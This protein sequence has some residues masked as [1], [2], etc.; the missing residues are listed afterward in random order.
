MLLLSVD[1][2]TA[3]SKLFF[4][5]C[6][7]KNENAWK[8]IPTETTKAPKKQENEKP[9]THLSKHQNMIGNLI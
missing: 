2:K 5:K 9:K 3:A 7:D 1:F 6:L 8:E 4:I